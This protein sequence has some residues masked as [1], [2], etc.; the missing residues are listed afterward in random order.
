M[1]SVTLS[2]E[3]AIKGVEL[4]NA[5]KAVAEQNGKRYYRNHDFVDGDVY[6]I[7]Q[8]SGYPYEHILVRP[9]GDEEFVRPEASYDKVIVTSHRWL[10]PVYPIGYEDT[11]VTEAVREFAA[12]LERYLS[13]APVAEESS[14]WP[15]AVTV[16]AL[17]DRIVSADLLGSKHCT[18]HGENP[19][20]RTVQ[21]TPVIG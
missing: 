15:Q 18:E 17:C 20:T 12:A 1:A 19:P 7:G 9:A 2:L 3:R 21:V 14:V 6:R 4:M 8:V 13:G 16:C 10:E 11:A 5:V